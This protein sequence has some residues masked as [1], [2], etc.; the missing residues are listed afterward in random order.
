MQDVEEVIKATIQAKVIEA[1]NS[2]G[3]AIEKLIACAINKPVDADSGGPVRSGYGTRQ[4]PYMDWLVGN[5][6]RRVIAECAREYVEEHRDELKA[7]VKQSIESGD[8]GTALSDAVMG[9][10]SERYNW[11]VKLEVGKD[12]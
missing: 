12:A 8:Y 4:M 6:I 2:S 7:K 9:V 10:L 1:F 5:E 11:N 3:D